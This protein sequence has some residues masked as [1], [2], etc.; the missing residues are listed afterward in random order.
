VGFRTLILVAAALGAAG[1]VEVALGD[2]DHAAG[3]AGVA[4]MAVALALCGRF[5]RAALAAI[6]A[7]LVA[8]AEGGGALVGETVT[9]VAVLAVAL[10]VAGRRAGDRWALAGAFALAAALAGVRIAYDPA[11][12]EVAQAV[13]TVVAVATPVVVGWWAREQRALQRELAATAERRARSR[14]RAARAAAE[15]ERGRIAA[16]LQLAVT[17]AL[18]SIVA[19]AGLLEQRL[20]AGD[21]RAARELLAEIAASARTALGDVRR[22]LGVLRRERGAAPLDPPGPVAGPAA[23]GAGRGPAP[24]VAGGPAAGPADRVAGGGQTPVA[25]PAAGVPGRAD[26]LAAA[27]VL[28]AGAVELAV[29]AG[30]L[31]ALTALPVALPLPWRRRRPLAVALVVLGAIAAQSLLV[32]PDRFPLADILAMVL[33]SYAIGAWSP[34]RRAVWAIAP[35]AA[36]VAAHA[37]VFH[38]GGLLAAL[39]GGVAL[40]WLVGVLVAV[41]RGLT[42]LG[43]RRAAEAE[44]ETARRAAAAVTSE[45]LRLARELHDAVAHNISVI[46]IQAGGAEG[47]VGRDHDR[48]AEVVRLVATVAREALGELRRITAEPDADA[49]GLERVP[50]LAA[51]ARAAGLD[52][53]VSIEGPPP[54]VPASV[55]LAAFRIVQE[56]LANTTKHARARRADVRVRFSPRAVELDVTDDGPGA[57]PRPPRQRRDGGGHGLVG[58]RERVA[59]YGGAFD[60]G[61]SA[62]GG[63]RV[64]AVLPLDAP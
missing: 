16:D 21:E 13:L 59:L 24:V 42:D 26:L 14:E 44:R 55:D 49:P 47:L 48:A 5:P 23:A 58:M 28:L 25:P 46:A 34:G 8:Q 19:A 57:G 41:D 31:A 39:L 38:P 9:T 35:V 33:A 51:R 56:A 62:G 36:G 10:Y 45:R 6:A 12:R 50:E 7:V 29:V 30:P 20:A 4:L 18:E 60:A 15:E 22:V 11:A 3:A 32:D 64:H 2:G 17:R 37:A 40:P 43:R 61:P 63:F 54:A 53:R 27:A 52:V 1:Q